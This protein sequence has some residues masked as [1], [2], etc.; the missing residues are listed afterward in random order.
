V[1]AGC[2]AE[3]MKQP[4]LIVAETPHYAF[5]QVDIHAEQPSLVTAADQV[6]ACVQAAL[7]QW[8]AGYRTMPALCRP[9]TYMPS[10][11]LRW[12]GLPPRSPCGFGFLASPLSPVGLSL[13]QRSNNVHYEAVTFAVTADSPAPL[14]AGCTYINQ[15]TL[16]GCF[17][18]VVYATAL[19]SGAAEKPSTCSAD[20][21]CTL[22][23]RQSSPGGLLATIPGLV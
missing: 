10:S 7:F 22:H 13:Q 6:N 14:R 20:P 9:G 17:D 21:E 4:Y 18:L 3:S 11:P 12:A 19:S 15:A 1:T 2:K 5:R 8:A 23:A 16:M